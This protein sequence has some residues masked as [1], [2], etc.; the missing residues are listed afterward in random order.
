VWCQ[1]YRLCHLLHTPQE[2][3]TPTPWE[4]WSRHRLVS[5]PLHFTLEALSHWQDITPKHPIYINEA[6]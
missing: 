1:W 2:A 4:S 3:Y 6:S 5:Y